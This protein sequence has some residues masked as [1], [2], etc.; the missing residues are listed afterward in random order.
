MAKKTERLKLPGQIRVDEA[1]AREIRDGADRDCRDL[2]DQLRWL[3]FMG[4]TVRRFQELSKGTSVAFC[5]QMSPA[6]NSEPCT[7]RSRAEAR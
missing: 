1:M 4:L 2:E 7:V 6:V 3:L 5:Q